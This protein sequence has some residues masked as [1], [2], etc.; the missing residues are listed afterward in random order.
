MQVKID[1]WFKINC[2]HSSY[3][4]YNA[5]LV[6]GIFKSFQAVL[7]KV[8][9]LKLNVYKGLKKCIMRHPDE[10]SSDGSASQALG[11]FLKR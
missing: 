6:W 9:H 5:R 10:E 1:K 7:N 8:N 3:L 11:C 2:L 4:A